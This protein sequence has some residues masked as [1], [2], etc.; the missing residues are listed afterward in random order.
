VPQLLTPFTHDQPD[1]SARVVKLGCG[2]IVKPSKYTGARVAAALAKLL[3]DARIA[4]AC[5]DIQSRFAGVDA[6]KQTC[7]LI[8]Q[9]GGQRSPKAH[10]VAHNEETLTATR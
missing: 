1:N 4:A 3:S 2:V 9:L 7:D 10:S 6:I 5:R 8:E